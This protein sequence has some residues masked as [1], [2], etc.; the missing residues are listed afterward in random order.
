MW[1][2]FG[3]HKYKLYSVLVFGPESVSYERS[4]RETADKYYHFPTR[5]FFEIIS[6]S[7]P[8][9][10]YCILVFSRNMF[11]KWIISVYFSVTRPGDP[12]ARPPVMDHRLS[13]LFVF[14]YF[15]VHELSKW[16]VFQYFQIQNL[17]KMIGFPIFPCQNWIK[18]DRFPVF[19][20]YQTSNAGQNQIKW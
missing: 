5:V 7:Q 18:M 13:K 16:F 1:H 6:K 3:C 9:M 14:Q 4:R 20:G 8:S 19:P 12:A 2:Y 10:I 15:Q 11:P 17:I